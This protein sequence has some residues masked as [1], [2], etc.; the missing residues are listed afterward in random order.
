LKNNV[1]YG[2][3]LNPKYPLLNVGSDGLQTLMYE[4][5]LTAWYAAISAS[6][7]YPACR[8]PGERLVSQ[9]TPD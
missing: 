9:L 7:P 6:T 1:S 4:P 5:F 2:C 8:I 3:K